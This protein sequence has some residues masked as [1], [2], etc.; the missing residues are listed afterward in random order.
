MTT[1]TYGHKNLCFF[2]GAG[3]DDSGIQYSIPLERGMD[4]RL[5]SHEVCYQQINSTIGISL[6]VLNKYLKLFSKM[7]YSCIFCDEKQETQQVTFRFPN[8]CFL[9]PLGQKCDCRK[10]FHHHFSVS[11]IDSQHQ[12]LTIDYNTIVNAELLLLNT[13]ENLEFF[14][15]SIE[16]EIHEAILFSRADYQNQKRP[17]IIGNGTS[18]LQFNE[19]TITVKEEKQQL[20]EPTNQYIINKEKQIL[21]AMMELSRPYFARKA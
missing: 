14:V 7:N 6:P 21:E 9:M 11:A 16:A 13:F 8:D 10:I 17:E 3:I 4:I 5:F 12:P 15:G 19:Q 2:C 20:Q 18:S 1:V